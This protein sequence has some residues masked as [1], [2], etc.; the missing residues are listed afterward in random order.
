MFLKGSDREQLDLSLLAGCYLCQDFDSC[1]VN[2][3]DPCQVQDEGGEGHG[4]GLQS[5]GRRTGRLPV[6]R[7]LSLL[8][9]TTVE[10]DITGRRFR[11]VDVR[12]KVI[13]QLK[14][15]YGL[16]LEETRRK[17]CEERVTGCVD[18]NSEH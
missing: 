10:V 11:C 14:L 8:N 17:R 9:V 15:R 16:Y 12:I 4:L 18:R 13:S 1:E 3:A 6:R 2:E 5:D 7:R